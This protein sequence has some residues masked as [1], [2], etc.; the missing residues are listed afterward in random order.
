MPIFL[1]ELMLLWWE[2]SMPNT[3]FR[4]EYGADTDL[5]ADCADYAQRKEKPRNAQEAGET[6]RIDAKR[7]SS[8]TVRE[9]IKPRSS[10]P[11][12]TVGLLPGSLFQGSSGSFASKN[13]EATDGLNS[14]ATGDIRLMNS[15][16]T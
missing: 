1:V 2:T 9:G 7:G 5:S 16:G 6:K 12:L 13:R 8:P 10:T 11:S 3:M 15:K 4:W 14:A